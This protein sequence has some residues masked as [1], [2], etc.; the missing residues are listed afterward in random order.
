MNYAASP[1]QFRFPLV[2]SALPEPEEWLP[3]LQESYEH[4]RFSNFGPV[5]TRLEA[6]LAAEFAGPDEAFV[7]TAS[8]T[9]G[10]AACLI[11]RNVRGR[12]LL[13]AFT[14]PASFAAIRMAGAEPW[15]V[16]IDT[17]TWACDLRKLARA[18]TTVKPRA[19]MLVAPFGV[20]QDFTQHVALCAAA[21]ATVVVD[22]AA[23][24]GGGPRQR[25]SLRGDGFEVFSL[26]ATKPFGIGE[27]GAVL[28]DVKSAQALRS[29]INFGLPQAGGT[30]PNWGIN[31]K[32]PE[33]LAA[34]GLAVLRG[35]PDVVRVRRQQAA[36]YVELL[37]RFDGIVF[38]RQLTEAPWQVFPCLLPSGTVTE[39]FLAETARMGLEV[40]RYYRP[41][42]ADWGGLECADDCSVAHDLAERMVTL[43]IYPRTDDDEIAEMHGIVAACLAKVLI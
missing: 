19:V 18:L 26:H 10:L 12:V 16:D 40:R 31:G 41:S 1:S 43:P 22:N 5:A 11:A 34:I 3:F 29:S 8:A 15:L 4:N 28:A 33:V 9:A 23:G 21:G 25:R 7:L 39:A 6:A 42:L 27:G 17:T 38:R 37:E 13:P 30:S 35:F 2:R 36:R 32:M 24:L 20:T 14:F